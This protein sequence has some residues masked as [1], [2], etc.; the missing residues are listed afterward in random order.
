[1]SARLG[2]HEDF[3]AGSWGAAREE[4]MLM[5]LRA[6]F[7]SYPDLAKQLRDS[8]GRSLAQASQGD[9]DHGIGLGVVDA[10]LGMTW[11]GKNFFGN[12][13]EL[14]RVEL[15]AAT[16]QKVANRKRGRKGENR[17]KTVAGKGGKEGG[18]EGQQ[19]RQPK[20]KEGHAAKAK[21]K[22]KPKLSQSRVKGVGRRM[23]CRIAQKGKR[24]QQESLSKAPL[25]YP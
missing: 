3:D 21:P 25:R 5:A 13:L 15:L 19:G 11:R 7:N 16:T 20:V 2:R 6:K 23:G 24:P 1:M 8:A 17:S 12:C 22:P 18:Q 10:K 4:K 14:L 9:C